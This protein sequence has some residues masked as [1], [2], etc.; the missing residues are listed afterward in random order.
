PGLTVDVQGGKTTREADTDSAADAV[1]TALRD[2][3]E[4]V[5]INTSNGY[6]GVEI[7]SADDART[8][9][10]TVRGMPEFTQLWRFSLSEPL[11]FSV[12]DVPT[13]FA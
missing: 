2:L 8:V 9:F 3:P 7:A 5:G 13:G 10:E 6:V 11:G 1:G 12:G 4:A